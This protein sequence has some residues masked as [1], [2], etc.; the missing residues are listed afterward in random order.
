MMNAKLSRRG[1]VWFICL[2]LMLA[3]AA[4]A[5]TLAAG[6]LAGAA[7]LPA[8]LPAPVE[9][10][11]ATVALEPAIGPAPDRYAR[12]TVTP[13]ASNVTR[14]A[15]TLDGGFPDGTRVTWNRGLAGITL[16][17]MLSVDGKRTRW[18]VGLGGLQQVWAGDDTEGGPIVHVEVG[19]DQDAALIPA[20][21]LVGGTIRLD[22]LTPDVEPAPTPTAIGPGDIWP[23]YPVPQKLV[24]FT[25][26]DFPC[27]GRSERLM[28]TLLANGV[29]ATF[30]VI[31]H[32]AEDS[33]ELLREA[34]L[35]G[36]S[37][38]NHTFSHRRLGA[39]SLTDARDEISRG[40]EA[41]QKATGE[42]PRYF[43]PPG[44]Q[45][46]P[47]LTALVAQMGL[48]MMLWDVMTNDYDHISADQIR[49]DIVTYVGARERAVV[50]LHDGS[51]ATVEAIGPIVHALRMS[52]YRLVTLNELLGR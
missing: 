31:G 52:G 20:D 27:P 40:T 10:K 16:P 28:E 12:L 1:P 43:R 9:P 14:W 50:C 3:S 8:T 46:T 38:G 51:A 13:L 26:D 4:A 49:R 42:T 18:Q 23:A 19:L 41:I 6:P 25:F 48:K 21:D 30:F 22:V 2:L 33:P 11:S 34:V 7:N 15:I 17:A 29:P 45:V 24:A 5:Q 36:F 35:D 37:L 44:G 47:A 39:A 32:K